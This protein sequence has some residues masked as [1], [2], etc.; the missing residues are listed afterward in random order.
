MDWKEYEKEVL[1]E[2][3]RVFLNSV[4]SYNVYIKGL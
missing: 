1:T 3:Q 4:I 2:C